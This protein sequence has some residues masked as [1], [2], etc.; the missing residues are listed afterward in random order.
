[1]KP[2]TFWFRFF[3]VLAL[4]FVTPESYAAE[5]PTISIKT[6]ADRTARAYLTDIMDHPRDQALIRVY[7]RDFNSVRNKLTNP[8][9]AYLFL[10]RAYA[11]LLNVPVSTFQN[12]PD[13]FR[14]VDTYEVWQV[15]NN[16]DNAY[17]WAAD[18]ATFEP[19]IKPKQNAPA[20]RDE[21]TWE[22]LHSDGIV[23]QD[24]LLTNGWIYGPQGFISS[25]KPTAPVKVVEPVDL[26]VAFDWDEVNWDE[27]YWPSLADGTG[28]LMDELCS[29]YYDTYGSQYAPLNCHAATQLEVRA[30]VVTENKRAKPDEEG[31]PTCP[32]E[33]VCKAEIETFEQLKSLEAADEEPNVVNE[34]LDWQS[35]TFEPLGFKAK[36]PSHAVHTVEMAP[37]SQVEWLWSVYHKLWKG[38][39]KVSRRDIVAPGLS[40]DIGIQVEIFSFPKEEMSALSPDQLKKALAAFIDEKSEETFQ[41]GSPKADLYREKVEEVFQGNSATRITRIF[42][43]DVAA[44]ALLF[45][46]QNRVFRLLIVIPT[47]YDSESIAQGFFDAFELIPVK[48]PPGEIFPEYYRPPRPM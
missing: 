17:I 32:L 38:S 42:K 36:F 22:Q 11:Q 26:P 46:A 34:V 6:A 31:L 18:G 40:H 12:F 8:E 37:P 23:D 30:L 20:G 16:A 48:F 15:M 3:A 4:V 5:R 35:Q 27:F 2:S 1:M 45:A 14:F 47:T 21:R 24:G 43:E 9:L 25:E 44:H 19:V 41:G 13:F 28:G 29:D 10:S 39:L 7:I 33:D